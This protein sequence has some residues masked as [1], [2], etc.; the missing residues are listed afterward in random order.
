MDDMS[1]KLSGAC[2]KTS[3]F[4]TIALLLCQTRVAMAQDATES[5]PESTKSATN[6]SPIEATTAPSSGG[7]ENLGT[8]FVPVLFYTPETQ[9]GLG[10]GVAHSYRWRGQEDAPPNNFVP[11]LIYTQ[12]KQTVFRLI[13]D[14]LS[15][16]GQWLWN[17]SIAYTNYPDRFYGVGNDTRLEDEELFTEVYG[18]IDASLQRKILPNT[19]AGLQARFERYYLKNRQIDGQLVAGEIEGA[20]AGSINGL[21]IRATHNTRN[22]AFIPTRGRLA[23]FSWINHNRSLGSSTNFTTTVGRYRRYWPVTPSW[24]LA[25]DLIVEDRSGDVPFRRMGLLGGQ[26]LMRGYFLGRFRDH[27]LS[28]LQIDTRHMFNQT[29]GMVLFMSTGWVGR[30]WNDFHL[31]DFHQSYGGGFRIVLDQK[32]QINLRLDYGVGRDSRAFY[33]GVGESF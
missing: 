14:H 33:M 2:V 15:E 9:F 23:E 17:S 30:S 32:A 1:R 19:F 26:Y 31:N 5:L 16:S 11:A 25:F 8:A 13:N 29:Y 22:S 6:E 24:V 10:V 20:D 7:I 28:A 12:R 21:G 4:I 3:A 18:L 27:K